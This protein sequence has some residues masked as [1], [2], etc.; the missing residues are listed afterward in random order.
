MRLICVMLFVWIS[1]N[2]F[3][4]ESVSLQ[5]TLL[6]SGDSLECSGEDLEEHDV[7]IDTE[8]VVD[9][10]SDKKNYVYNNDTA[11]RS[12]FDQIITIDNKVITAQVTNI[13]LNQVHYR[14]PLNSISNTISREMINCIIHKNG[15]KEIFTL[16]DKVEEPD[17][18]ADENFII[19]REKKQWEEVDTTHNAEKIL[20]MN[21]LESINAKYESGKM[22]AN[23]E[24]LEKNAL[25][26]LRKKAANLGADLILITGKQLHTAYGDL[27][28]IELEGVAYTKDIAKQ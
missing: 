13:G 2:A 14:Y 5:D 22:R 28:S 15:R 10:V 19:A 1:W 12:N 18:N 26:I 27:P 20:G 7:I 21:K 4:Q 8:S 3:G 16:V 17:L 25:I 6:I 9:S 11:Y 23:A 24:Y